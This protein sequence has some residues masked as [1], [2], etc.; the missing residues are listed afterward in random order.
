MQLDNGRINFRTGE[1]TAVADG[2]QQLRF[3]VIPNCGAYCSAGAGTWFGAQSFSSFF[4][5]HYRNGFYRQLFL[6][7]FHH[8]RR[9]NVIGQICTNSNVQTGKFLLQKFGKIQLQ[10]ISQNHMDIA[11]GTERFLKDRKKTVV[12]FHCTNFFCA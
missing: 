11:V 2:E 9:S 3:C 4:L 1:K 12:Q 7:Q 10:D 8:D 5:H 6:Q